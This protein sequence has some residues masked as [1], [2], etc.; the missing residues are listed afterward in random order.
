M[1]A[2]NWQL[3]TVQQVWNEYQNGLNGGPSLRQLEEECGAEWRSETN[4]RKFFNTRLAIYEEIKRRIGPPLHESEAYVVKDLEAWHGKIER[5]GKLTKHALPE[6]GAAL[7]Q[8]HLL[9]DYTAPYRKKDKPNAKDK[10]V[11]LGDYAFMH[12]T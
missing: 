3:A 6:L 7:Q 11:C 8:F 2:G 12:S 1:A 5:K 9:N 4:N 10:S